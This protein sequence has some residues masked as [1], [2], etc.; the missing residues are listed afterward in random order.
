MDAYPAGSVVRRL[1]ANGLQFSHSV[2]RP[3][4]VLRPHTHAN[5]YI[6][7]VQVGSYTER[8]GG[9]VRRCDSSTLL[10]H[11]AGET[12]ENRFDA[13]PVQLLRIEAL[14]SDWFA[15][16]APRLPGDCTRDAHAAFL[17]QGML[18]ELRSP[19]DLTSLVLEGLAYELVAA[20]GRGARRHA[21]PGPL[22]L[23]R[24][25][26]LLLETFLEPLDLGELA[27][28]VHVHPVHLA[29][30]FRRHRGQT[31]GARVRELRLAEACRRLA[32]SRASVAEIAL[33]C[34]FADQSHLARL[35]RRILGTTPSRYREDHSVPSR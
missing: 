8:V 34:G 14:S 9:R 35:M 5:A 33:A 28:V 16:Q 17:C 32:E 25:D 12:H 7:F 4:A 31:V 22:W 21:E 3:H 6:S 26:A 10:C 27:R 15:A 23:R 13:E 24:I 1:V 19:D 11:G 2:Y 29:R 30:T 18:G 20:L